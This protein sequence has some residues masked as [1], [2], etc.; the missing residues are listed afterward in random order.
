M[1]QTFVA[2]PQCR[3]KVNLEFVSNS[4]AAVRLANKPRKVGSI[5]LPKRLADL[6]YTEEIPAILI[7]DG[8]SLL[9][10]GKSIPVGKLS[11]LMVS[12]EG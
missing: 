7:D 5:L 6:R 4:V 10:I 2:E 1:T 8:Y 12:G 9:P 11:K 3:S